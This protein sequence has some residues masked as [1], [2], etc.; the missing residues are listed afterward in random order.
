MRKSLL[1]RI[2]AYLRRLVGIDDPER[3]S[4]EFKKL[5]GRGDSGGWSFNRDEIHERTKH[6]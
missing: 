4:V 3:S 2:R 6:S 1:D 5:S